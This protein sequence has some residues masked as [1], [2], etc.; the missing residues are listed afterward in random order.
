M[1]SRFS[2]HHAADRDLVHL[3]DGLADDGESVVAD[4]PVRHQVVRTDQ[5]S[6]IDLA[7]VDELVD[8]DGARRFQRHVLELLLRYLDE[9]VGV[10]LVAFDDVLVG[11]LLAGVRVDLG[12]LDAMAG[13]PI[14]LVERDR[15]GFR[16]G[17]IQRYRTGD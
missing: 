8:L 13:P 7:A 2:Q 4:L 14:E 3:S 5:I 11:D 17:R 1:C 10:D 6:R 16:R 12:V 9:A 15:F